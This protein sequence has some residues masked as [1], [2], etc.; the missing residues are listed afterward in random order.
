MIEKLAEN[1]AVP[2][3]SHVLDAGCGE[4]SVAIYLAK[5]YQLN[6]TGIDLL[7]FNISNAESSRIK[8]G[9]ND[10]VTFK[11]AD[12]SKTGF[13]NS[14]FDAIYT[15]ETLVHAPNYKETIKEFHR[16]LK[17]GGKLVLF[18]YSMAPDGEIPA[19]AKQAFSKVNQLSSR[20]Q[21]FFKLNS[22]SS[23][24]LSGSILIVE[25]P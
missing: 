9:L 6:I 2:A 18:E 19:E 20:T 4:G 13:P 7:D 21:L 16:L 11:L 14:S 22:A 1:L 12:Y 23:Y 15:M 8:L 25:Y 3:G 10:Q 24:L 5:K 17:P